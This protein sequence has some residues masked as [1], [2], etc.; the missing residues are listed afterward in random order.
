[1]DTIEVTAG[2]FSDSRRARQ[3]LAGARFIS[4]IGHVEGTSLS[5]WASVQALKA[6]E[7]DSTIIDTV[8]MVGFGPVS[9]R[10]TYPDGMEFSEPVGF[11]LQV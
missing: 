1:M 2:I 11:L 8:M 5:I 7:S 6:M 3:S 9:V 10:T 4:A